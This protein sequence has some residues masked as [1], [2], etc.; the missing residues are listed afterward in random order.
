MSDIK[1]I[2]SLLREYNKIIERL[3]NDNQKQILRS[4]NA[5]LGDLAE[6]LFEELWNGKRE[7]NSTKGVDLKIGDI[8]YQ[9]KARKVDKDENKTRF[10]F[11]DIK[12]VQKPHF[13]IFAFIIFNKDYTIRFAGQMSY[14]DILNRVYNESKGTKYQ[15]F[16]LDFTK[17]NHFFDD[18][19]KNNLSNILQETKR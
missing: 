11:R 19:L 1:P 9:I 18:V 3:K 15:A 6:F 7:T 5:P 13:D 10:N 16:I 12:D 4:D 17:D 14:K 2:L 8:K